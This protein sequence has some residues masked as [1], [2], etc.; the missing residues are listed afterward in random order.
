MF[1]IFANVTVAAGIVAA[2]DPVP[3]PVTS[4]VNAI[5][6]SPVFDPLLL[7]EPLGY[8]VS[9]YD[10]SVD[11]TFIQLS[12]FSILDAAL[13]IMPIMSASTGVVFA[14]APS[15]NAPIVTTVSPFAITP[16]PIDTPDIDIPQDHDFYICQNLYRIY[17]RVLNCF[18]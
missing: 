1:A 10:L 4:P 12:F 7:P 5:V 8:K 18:G 11:L 2:I 9:K 16:V 13:S 6:W 15:I 14:V 17:R 3:L